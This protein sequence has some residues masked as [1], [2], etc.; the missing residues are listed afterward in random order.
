MSKPHEDYD[1]EIDDSGGVTHDDYLRAKAL[2]ETALEYFSKWSARI[3]PTKI[4]TEDGEGE[5]EIDLF[6]PFWGESWSGREIVPQAK[7]WREPDGMYIII[8]NNPEVSDALQDEFYEI[9][10]QKAH[11]SRA[12][13]P[14]IQER[15]EVI[16]KILSTFP[17]VTDANSTAS[18]TAIVSTTAATTT[19]SSTTTSSTTAATTTTATTTAILGD[20]IVCETEARTEVVVD[21][22]K[23][24]GAK[25]IRFRILL[26]EGSYYGIGDGFVGSEGTH[27][28]NIRPLWVSL[29]DYDNVLGFVRVLERHGVSGFADSIQFIDS[30]DEE[31][32]TVK[33]GEVQST[34]AIA[35]YAY[36]NDYS[37]EGE[38]AIVT[39]FQFYTKEM[40]A[41]K[42]K[43]LF[44][45]ANWES[46]KQK[47]EIMEALKKD[48][49]RMTKR[50]KSKWNGLGAA[51]LEEH[52][53]AKERLPFSPI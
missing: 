25:Y 31:K 28:T 11:Y 44:L 46:S 23:A 22:S 45:D 40:K 17:A 12:S 19:T 30:L 21:A 52:N 32:S 3:E 39:P 34:N 38:L 15:I 48:W 43:E 4:P 47:T 37:I 2:L 29:G 13:V 16:E 42:K 20:V 1:D 33:I 5:E 24:I 53:T 26:A 10:A 14:I 49:D 18:A 50:Q 51:S 36:G 35:R 9:F 7:G 6:M 27:A 41:E 8:E